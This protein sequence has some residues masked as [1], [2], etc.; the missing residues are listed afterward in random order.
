MKRIGKSDRVNETVQK[1]AY[2]PGVVPE[3]SHRETLAARCPSNWCGK[4]RRSIR[5][6]GAATK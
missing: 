6:E 2:I 5:I 1:R 4:V 3:P